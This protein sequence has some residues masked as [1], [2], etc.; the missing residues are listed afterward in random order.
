MDWSAVRKV[1]GQNARPE[2]RFHSRS[3]AGWFREGA[4][5]RVTPRGLILRAPDT[6]PRR[7]PGVLHNVFAGHA[8]SGRTLQVF[9]GGYKASFVSPLRMANGP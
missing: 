7:N 1:D 4:N 6:A 3:Q 2:M 8:I 9:A 5:A